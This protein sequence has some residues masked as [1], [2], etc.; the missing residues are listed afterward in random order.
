MYIC[1]YVYISTNYFKGCVARQK[2]PCGALVFCGLSLSVCVFSAGKTNTIE[3]VA[4]KVS[5]VTCL[6]VHIGV[7]IW[8]ARIRQHSRGFAHVGRCGPQTVRSFQKG[9]GKIRHFRSE[10]CA[11]PEREARP[12]SGLPT[13]SMM[14]GIGSRHA[15]KFT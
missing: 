2:I 12:F 7:P 5:K 3:E 4:S 9:D 8:A 1:I 15:C 13:L 14:R 10:G 6:I 11:V